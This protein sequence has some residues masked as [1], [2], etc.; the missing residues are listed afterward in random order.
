ME[1]RLLKV[2]K[3]LWE[4]R[5]HTDMNSRDTLA[6]ELNVLGKFDPFVPKN[7]QN[8]EFLMLGNLDPIV[9]RKALKQLKNDPNLSC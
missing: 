7:Y 1:F 5:Y 4:G 8:C 3:P 6:T 9:Q 2:A